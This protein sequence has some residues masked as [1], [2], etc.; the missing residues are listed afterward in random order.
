MWK[1]NLVVVILILRIS[2]AR[3]LH[4]RLVFVFHYLFLSFYFQSAYLFFS[5]AECK[6]IRAADPGKPNLTVMKEAAARWA[7]LDET[8]RKP[9]VAKAA[10]DKERFAKETSVYNGAKEE[11]EEVAEE[12]EEDDVEEDDDEG[13]E[14]EEEED[15]DED[16]DDRPHKLVAWSP[17]QRYL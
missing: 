16:W 1:A 8:A 7:Q 12:V 11:E 17:G 6:K 5:Q 2:Q 9:W 3:D 14:E 15:E 13:D 4:Y 10:K